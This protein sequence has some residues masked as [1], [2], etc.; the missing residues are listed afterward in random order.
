MGLRLRDLGVTFGWLDLDSIVRCAPRDSAL[1][2]MLDPDNAPW[3]LTEQLLHSVEYSLRLLLWSKSE[4]AANGRT[5]TAPDPVPAP[6]IKDEKKQ[7]SKIGSD[8]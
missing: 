3:G 2:R 5:S 4:D 7:A 6:W 8:P 1:A